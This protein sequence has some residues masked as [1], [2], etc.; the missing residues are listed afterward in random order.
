M[1]RSTS[2]RREVKRSAFAAAVHA[3][4]WLGCGA[5]QAQSEKPL[6]EIVTLDPG[7]FHAALVQKFMLP[8]VSPD[9]RVYAPA[10]DD[11]IEH[12]KRIERFNARADRPTSWKEQV[13]TGSDYL[14]RAVTSANLMITGGHTTGV[15]L[16]PTMV[17]ISGNNARKTEYITRAIGAGMNVLAD[18]P[19]AITPEGYRELEAAF[20]MAKKKR[21]LLYD[22]MT[23]R[24]EITTMLQKA[25]AQQPRLFG[26]LERGTPDNPAITKISVHHFAKVVAGAALK[27]PQWFFDARQQGAGI[28]DVT[29][30]LVDLVQWAAFPEVALK[31]ADAKVLSARRWGTAITPAQF[32]Q[33]TGA[34]QFPDYLQRDVRDGVLH[35]GSNGEFTY[36]LR[37]VHA[38][39]SV[40]WNFEA[41]AGAGDTHFSVMR[42]TLANL[43][44][45]QGA[46][47]GYK[48]VLYVERAP[49]VSPDRFVPV[50]QA[51]VAALQKTWPGVGLRNEGEHWIVTVPEKYHDGHEAHFTQV[52]QNFLEYLRAG[53]L[54]AWEVPN[55]LTKYSTIMQAYEMSRP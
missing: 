33:V 28:V 47:Q 45:K 9:V 42:G 31:P 2:P 43:V 40:T 12:I 39:V 53:K 30:H 44:I 11:V 20:A 55:M 8:G 5:A 41:P 51:T 15:R 13:Y 37:G 48:P 34:K 18:K 21:V 3:S 50:L 32:E 46:E 22:I 27:R 14:E 25:L 1:A 6:V 23:E 7:H 4:L 35:A 26:V 10:G 17:V 16:V 38:K 29:T 19:M 24:F 52:T 49:S 36:T 54:H